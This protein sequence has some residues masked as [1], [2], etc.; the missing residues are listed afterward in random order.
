ML[1]IPPR[2]SLVYRLRIVTGFSLERVLSSFA[3]REH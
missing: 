1:G 2:G 3:R